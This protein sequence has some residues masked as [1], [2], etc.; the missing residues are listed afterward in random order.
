MEHIDSH[1]IQSMG[2]NPIN[3]EELKHAGENLNTQNYPDLLNLG[4]ENA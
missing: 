3:E 1:K 2:A 4:A